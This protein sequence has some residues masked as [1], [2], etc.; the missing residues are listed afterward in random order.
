VAVENGVAEKEKG[1]EQRNGQ[2]II[3]IVFGEACQIKTQG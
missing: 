2:R 3:K 1:T